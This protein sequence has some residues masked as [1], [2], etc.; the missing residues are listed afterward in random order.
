MP[1]LCP[2]VFGDSIG[3]P[4]IPRPGARFSYPSLI[5][6]PSPM[7]EGAVAPS[8]PRRLGYA[9][10]TTKG[11]RMRSVLLTA[12]AAVMMSATAAI[13]DNKSDCQKGVAMIKAELKKKHSAPVLVT[14]RK[15]LS[16]AETE[17]IEEDWSECMDH[18]KT[19]RGALSK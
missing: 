19:A 8:L 2:P 13:A 4:R 9:S 16:D 7:C 6:P 15:A 11:S 12:T 1:K 3:R 10:L 18:I 5:T 14:L 17:V